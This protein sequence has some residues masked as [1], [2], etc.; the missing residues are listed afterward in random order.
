M[1]KRLWSLL[2]FV[3][4]TT[5]AQDLNFLPHFNASNP[6][7][8]Q[9]IRTIEQDKYGFIWFGTQE[10]VHRYDGKQFKS[11]HHDVLEPTSL[12]SD[13]VSRM[14]FDQRDQLWIGTRGGG[15]NVMTLGQKHFRHITTQSKNHQLSHNNVNTLM[16]DSRGSIWVGTEKGL[17]VLRFDANGELNEIRKHFKANL[18][19]NGLNHDIIHA[20][21]EIGHNEI[22]IGTSGG[23]ISAFDLDGN[24]KYDI[25]ITDSRVNLVNSLVLDND[26]QVWIGTVEHGLFKYHLPT[27]K[28]SHYVVER[29]NPLSIPSNT[30]ENVIEDSTGRV[31]IATDNGLAI[32]NRQ[33]DNFWRYKHNPTNPFS[34]TND[35]VLTF[36]ED[37]NGMMWIGTL[38]GVSR[39]D[40]KLTTFSQYNTQKYP[41]LGNS[42]ITDF[43]Q[44]DESRIAFSTYSGG[45]YTLEQSN[46]EISLLPLP[47]DLLNY[48]IMSLLVDDE[49]IWI[50]TRTA[51]LFKY[52]TA[53]NI[54]VHFAHDENNPSSISAN[55]ITDIVKLSNGELW[56]STY[57]KGLNRLNNDLTFTRFQPNKES[58]DSG[59]SSDHIVKIIEGELEELWLATYGGGIN[60]LDLNSMQFTHLTHD[61]NDSQSIS[62][63]LSWIIYRDKQ[64]NLWV[65]TQAAGL[66]FLSLESQRKQ[67]YKF[68]RYN[69][70]DGM[71]SR[72]VYGISQDKE[73]NIWFSTNKGISRFSPDSKNFKH[74][75]MA[76]G[77]TELEYNHGAYYQ[78]PKY[79][80]YFGSSNGFTGV[81][82]DKVNMNHTAPIVRLVNIYRLNEVMNFDKAMAELGEV[83]FDYK[84]QVVTFEYVGLN[85]SDPDSTQYKY[86]LIGFDEEW[87]DAG[88]SQRATYTNLPSGQYA[89]EVIAQNSDGIWS[90]PTTLVSIWVAPKPWNTWWAY[91][92]YICMIAG[93]VLAYSRFINRKLVQEQQ[94]RLDLKQQVEE[95]THHLQLKNKEL[96]RANMQLENAAIVDK[97]TNVKSRRYLDIYIEQ[98]SKLMMQ[99]HQNLS[100]VERHLLPKLFMCMVRLPKDTTNSLLLN[101]VDILAYSSG[102]EDLIIRWD[103]STFAIIGYDNENQVTN[104]AQSL[105]N[106]I[107]GSAQINTSAKIVFSYYPFDIEDTTHVN[108]DQMSVLAEHCLKLMNKDGEMQWLGL[109]GPNEKPFDYIAAIKSETV[110]ELKQF[111]LI[112][113]G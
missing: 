79:N 66:N 2:F 95:K 38:A 102:E 54:L 23:G 51:G 90:E 43:S 8:Y 50:G 70:K 3:S 1:L 28:L 26:Q 61:D 60:R 32:Y 13:V 12:S 11:F 44:Y 21:V 77:L 29:D 46:D 92:L 42:T 75:G 106:R 6:L 63:D 41:S 105:A 113:Q 52:N 84:D 35:F 59:P 40:P 48:R 86:R 110:E 20:I 68:L 104:L 45:I 96:Q 88:K 9:M 73:N 112:K 65:G 31:W 108:W 10:G 15:L 83:A 4:L 93:L 30:I 69:V 81:A 74:F 89:L 98:A 5:I 78:D 94:M 97:L 33:T 25:N 87:I 49:Q 101:L 57:H 62:S 76:H 36:F 107:K 80:L 17:N 72:T 39:W 22:W 47:Q 58:P 71:K 34:L 53:T 103:E 14:L 55:S 24:Y 64:G 67:D 85:F 7:S 82:P 56:V 18:P 100:P 27:R 111:A 16:E 109:L 19:E 91:T 99:I 37:V